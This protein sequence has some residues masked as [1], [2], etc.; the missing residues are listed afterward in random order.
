MKI[1]FE[2]GRLQSA[3]QSISYFMINRVEIATQ[4]NT[5][6][7]KMGSYKKTTRVDLKQN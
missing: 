6:S 1:R 3:S 4:C 5:K 7:M 2:V